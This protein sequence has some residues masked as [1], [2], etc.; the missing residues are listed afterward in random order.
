VIRARGPEDDG[1][2]YRAS[3]R[4]RRARVEQTANI[5]NVMRPRC[6]VGGTVLPE[7]NR[8]LTMFGGF[9]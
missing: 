6:G 5:S 9:G 1:A 7:I 2:P 3:A 8:A 4:A